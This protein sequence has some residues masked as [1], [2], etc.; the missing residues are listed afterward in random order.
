MPLKSYKGFNADMSCRGVKFAV[1]GEYVHEGAVK[2]CS[3]GFHA[4]EYPLDVLQYYPPNT[5]VYAEVEQD[6]EISKHSD[7]SK[8]ASKILRVKASLSL[9]GLIKAA[10][11][12]TFARSTLEGLSATGDQG[13]A[14]ATGCQG[15]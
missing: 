2:A 8:V 5:S 13:A 6:G 14:S 7:D 3:A 11:D 12:Y 10:I 15:A 9:S 4:C 1:G